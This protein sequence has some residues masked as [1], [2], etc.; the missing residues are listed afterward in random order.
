MRC[1]DRVTG[2][3]APGG[4][5]CGTLGF[6]RITP[7]SADRA[8]ASARSPG[9]DTSSR[10]PPASTTTVCRGCAS[11]LVHRATAGERLDGVVPLG[12]DPAG[13]DGEAVLIA[14]E[15]RVAQHRTVEQDDGGEALDVEL[16][17]A[18]RARSIADAGRRR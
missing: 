10:R 4:R 5:A 3:P 11:L 8:V 13:V 15:G 2:N 9:S 16:V 6:L 17:R 1:G 18:R 7:G 14:D 12:L